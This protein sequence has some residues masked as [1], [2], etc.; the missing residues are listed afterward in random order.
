MLTHAMIK[1][2]GWLLALANKSSVLGCVKLTVFNIV[3]GDQ[4][5]SGQT[6]GSEQS[7]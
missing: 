7:R 4:P 6:R 2:S 5:F 1:R 3:F